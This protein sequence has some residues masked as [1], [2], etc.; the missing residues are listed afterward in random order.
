M[1]L[2]EG[3]TADIEAMVRLESDPACNLWVSQWTP[4]RHRA[5]M[6]D[7]QHHYVV[8][9]TDDGDWVGFAFLRDVHS[10]NR[11]IEMQRIAVNRPDQGYGRALL[12][13][14]TWLA[15]ERYGA[16]RLWF[17]VIETNERARHVYRALGFAEEGLF[18]EARLYRDGRFYSLVLMG[19]L[20]A[21]YR[22]RR[23]TFLG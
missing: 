9:E 8:A 18:R 15:F 12:K 3:T 17:D 1:R 11:C 14:V 16:H 6:E 4:E 22:Q 20:E 7:G 13:R 19:M 5:A 2:R 23:A 10:A 21:E